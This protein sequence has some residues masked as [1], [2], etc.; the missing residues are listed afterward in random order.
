MKHE[1]TKSLSAKAFRR[2]TGVQRKTFDQMVGILKKAEA[3]RRRK[4]GHKSKLPIED[5]LLLA[6]EYLREYRA[7]FHI[8]QGFGV[9]ET[10]AIRISRRVED[11]LVKGG[12]FSL[13]GKEA[14]LGSGIEYGTIQI[15][16]AES[17]VERQKKQEAQET[18]DKEP[19]EQAKRLLSR[20]EEAPH[21]EG[22]SGC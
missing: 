4:G 11:A 16:V 8:A 15:D 12:A 1:K 18:A 13:P 3:A 5:M 9:H 21:D 6:L 17:P 22:P 10:S 20:Q 14:L 19:Q 7:Y 2:L